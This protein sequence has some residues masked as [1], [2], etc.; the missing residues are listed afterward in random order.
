MNCQNFNFHFLPTEWSAFISWRAFF[1]IVLFELE[2]LETIR[3]WYYCNCTQRW[4]EFL[5]VN[6]RS[7]RFTSALLAWS[8]HED[9]KKLY[10][11]FFLL[12]YKI[13]IPLLKKQ[14]FV[15]FVTT[16]IHHI[17]FIC[18]FRWSVRLKPSFKAIIRARRTMEF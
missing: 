11:T 16:Q 8:K 9:I 2:L 15:Y 3:W 6:C 18:K 1:L 17:F 10:W 7:L 5:R 14:N 4:M 12:F 13:T